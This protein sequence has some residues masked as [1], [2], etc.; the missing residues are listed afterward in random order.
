MYE[1][2]ALKNHSFKHALR[3]VWRVAIVLSCHSYQYYSFGRLHIFFMKFIS[4]SFL[5]GTPWG[6]VLVVFE[7]RLNYMYTRRQLNVLLCRAFLW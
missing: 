5:D 3:I 2:D 7:R 6:A 1:K 4:W